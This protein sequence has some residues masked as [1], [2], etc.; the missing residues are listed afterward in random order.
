MGKRVTGGK[1]PQLQQSRLLRENKTEQNTTALG[2]GAGGRLPSRGAGAASGAPALPRAGPG[3][4]SLSEQPC[5]WEPTFSREGLSKLSIWLFSSLL[6]RRLQL[7]PRVF[8]REFL[9]N[10]GWGRRQRCAG[11]RGLCA[12]SSDCPSLA[13]SPASGW[14]RPLSPDPEPVLRGLGGCR[15]GSL[16]PPPGLLVSRLGSPAVA[17]RAPQAF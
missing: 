12:L 17:A 10:W 2:P 13:P 8:L 15:E 9:R 16:G 1:C 4:P 7:E 6:R 5:L 3:A 11:L 14:L